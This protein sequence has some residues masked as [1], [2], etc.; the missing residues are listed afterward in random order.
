MRVQ[1][2]VSKIEARDSSL[3]SQSAHGKNVG[4]GIALHAET[5]ASGSM[6][7]P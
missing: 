3:A 7:P 1:I 5:I 4:A 2:M 6:T